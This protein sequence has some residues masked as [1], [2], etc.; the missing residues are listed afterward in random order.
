MVTYDHKLWSSLSDRASIIIQLDLYDQIILCLTYKSYVYYNNKIT[1]YFHI[2][3]SIWRHHMKALG[4][5]KT[6][7]K[8]HL[9]HNPRFPV[10][11][12]KTH[13]GR[14]DQAIHR[15]CL[16]WSRNSQNCKEMIGT[17]NR[18]LHPKNWWWI[19]IDGQYRPYKIA[20]NV[21]T[22]AMSDGSGSSM[23]KLSLTSKISSSSFP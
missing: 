11:R 20:S 18:Q 3:N 14:R 23:N 6:F 15:R 21:T 2:Y 1:K 17:S 4:R 12:Y 22:W 16:F 13:F 9:I 19:I 5:T 10:F 8:S 7:L